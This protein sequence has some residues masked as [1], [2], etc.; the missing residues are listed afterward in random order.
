[1]LSESQ[2]NQFKVDGY[3]VVRQ[4]AP[5]DQI[6]LLRK[7]HQ[8]LIEQ[9]ADELGT[10][11]ENY[12]RVVSQWTNVRHQHKAFEA[13]IY[14]PP[15]ASSAQ[16]LLGGVKSV[17]LF[18]DHIISKPAHHS[19]TIPWHQDYPFWPVDQPNAVSC[20]LAL[21]D[22]TEETG[23]MYF[24]PGTHREG[25]KP[26]VDFLNTPWTWGKRETE[27]VSTSLKA[28]DC[29]FHHCLTWHTS[30]PN[31]STDPRRAFIMIMMDGA[32]RWAPDH[33]DWHPMNDYVSVQPGEHFNADQFPILTSIYGDVQ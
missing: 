12:E 2:V 11:V 28:G 29:V 14:H 9:W 32:C 7:A 17:Q 26:P 4:I 3:L 1:M 5:P 16:Q 24:M 23:S 21:D 27:K 25:E 10:S 22:A 30:P 15:I 31:R 33:S 19:S 18:H 20:W 13:Q 8:S 6:D